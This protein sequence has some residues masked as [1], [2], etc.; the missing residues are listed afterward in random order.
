MSFKAIVV[1]LSLTA[2]VSAFSQVVPQAEQGRLPFSV[3]GGFSDFLSS[4]GSG[5]RLTGGAVWVDS[6]PT[7]LP[8]SQHGFGLE[9]ESRYVSNP[10]SKSH[11]SGIFHQG[12][13]GGGPTYTLL[14]FSRFHPYAKFI[15]SF[16]GQSFFV[17]AHA[18]HHD[19]QNVYAPGGGVDCRL[20]SHLW[21]RVDYEYQIWPNPF[22][23]PNWTLDPQ[24]WTVGGSWDFGSMHRH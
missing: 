20:F 14:R 3:G 4:D 7:M 22:S 23:N 15:V 24:G 1:A 10:Q 16:A 2:T 5:H 9:A 8:L 11:E 17:G 21:A 19:T 18:Y 6:R 13:V 12:T